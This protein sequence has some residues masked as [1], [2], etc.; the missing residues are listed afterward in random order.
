MSNRDYLIRVNSDG[1]LDSAFNSPSLTRP[2]AAAAADNT[3]FL[4]GG[5]FTNDGLDYLARLW[6]ASVPS[7]GSAQSS[8][9]TTNGFTV[10]STVSANRTPADASCRIATTA[11][12]LDS[13]DPVPATPS[14]ISASDVP[15]S[16]SF[17]D[18]LPGTDYYV[19]VYASNGVG[20]A[21]PSSVVHVTT[22]VAAPT[23][24]AAE[25]ASVTRTGFAVTSTVSYGGG[26]TSVKCRIASSE[27]GVDTA[28]PVNASPA[29]VGAANVPV[30]CSFSN[31]SPATDYYVKV[32]A[33]NT[34]GNADSGNALHVKTNSASAPVV[35][36]PNAPAVDSRSASVAATV[37]ANGASATVSCA[38]ASSEAGLA[39]AG[40]SVAAVPAT[41]TGDDVAVSCSFA[42]LSPGTK[43]FYRVS[44]LNQ[45][46]TS[47]SQVQSFTTASVPPGVA[48]SLKVSGA[49]KAK[50]RI[51]TWLAP[52]VPG[53]S[54]NLSYRVTIKRGSKTML[55][56][57]VTALKLQFTKSKAYKAGKY[58]AFVQAGNSAGYATAVKKAFKI[59]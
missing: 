1:T 13:A 54:E 22:D 7:V 10:S 46:G 12:A 37:S 23:V 11:V 18:L 35:V 56:K 16:C 6:N 21:T 57:T 25:V 58:T 52:V 47:S 48:R 38:V 50:K 41:V 4:V 9:V 42:G 19:K 14:M 45:A 44:T 53:T 8:A 33:S 2:V 39:S 40:Q 26:S 32:Y 27:G 59:K 30:G 17:S 55:T 34:A 31:L 3:G 5:T 36:S 51:V 29:T 28:N 24:A 20:D 15:V 43:Y 49:V